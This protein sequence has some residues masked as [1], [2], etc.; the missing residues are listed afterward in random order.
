MSDPNLDELEGEYD[1]AP[2]EE[3]GRCERCDQ[4]VSPTYGCECEG[5]AR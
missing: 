2:A 1:L 5:P 3:L 4:T